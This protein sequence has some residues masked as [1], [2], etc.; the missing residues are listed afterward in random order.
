M[1]LT[2]KFTVQQLE[3]MTKAAR[4]AVQSP[5]ASDFWKQVEERMNVRDKS[6]QIIPRKLK[7]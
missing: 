5:G 1:K 4:V 3:E 2:P 7:F 6:K